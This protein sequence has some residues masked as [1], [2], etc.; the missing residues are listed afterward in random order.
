M[1]WRTLFRSDHL[2]ALTPDDHAALAR[3]GLARAF[4]FRGVHERAAGSY[5]LPGVA[6]HPLPIEPT[7]VQ[8]MKDLLVA[9][10]ELTP[11]QTVALMQETYRAFVNDNTGAYAALFQHLLASDAPLVF[12]CTAGKDRTGM[13]AAIEAIH[14]G[15]E[16]RLGR[17]LAL[18]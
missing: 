4:D 16:F 5:K 9:G 1:R 3:L 2:A 6:Q 15:H 12:H 18:P 8:R 13:V 10:R 17:K 14:H 7:V 11:Q